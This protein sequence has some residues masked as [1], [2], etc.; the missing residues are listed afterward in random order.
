MSGAKAHAQG[1]ASCTTACPAAA[2]ARAAREHATQ[3]KCMAAMHHENK[4][5]AGIVKSP[6]CQPSCWR[7]WKVVVAIVYF[8]LPFP[9]E[10]VTHPQMS[11]GWVHQE[12]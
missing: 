10:S 8:C 2:P 5:F 12:V 9:R 4:P 3:A 11:L 6:A 1:A 7:C